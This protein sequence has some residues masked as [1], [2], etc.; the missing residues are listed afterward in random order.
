MALYQIVYISAATVSFSDED[1]RELLDIAR[2]NN[3]AQGVSGMLV[4]HEGS[5]IQ[6][7]EGERVAVE[8]VYEKIETDERHS[9]QTV[10]L[11]GDIEHRTFESW[12][13]A[14]LPSSSLSDI[15]AGFHPF[16]RQRSCKSDDTENAARDAL[17]AFKEGRWRAR[18]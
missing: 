15:P 9:N 5:F 17:N 2:T 11:R 3:A 4:Y 7:L 14:F 12:A 8:S 10:L 1:L 16:L 18:L 6:V 13:M